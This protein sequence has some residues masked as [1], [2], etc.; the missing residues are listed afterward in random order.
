MSSVLL[1]IIG[2]KMLARRI[3]AGF[4][5]TFKTRHL[6]LGRRQLETI[7]QEKAVVK[8]LNSTLISTVMIIFNCG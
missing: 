6:T 7:A 1:T 4:A 2:D 8:Y 5:E 3:P